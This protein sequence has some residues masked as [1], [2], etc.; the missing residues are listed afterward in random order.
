MRIEQ[1]KKGDNLV[2]YHIHDIER[3][4]IDQLKLLPDVI[5][6]IDGRMHYFSNVPGQN[7]TVLQVY[8]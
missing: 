4:T 2:V 8:I 1:F 5:E 7:Y 3:R 6:V